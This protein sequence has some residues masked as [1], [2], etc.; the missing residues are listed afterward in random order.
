M[1]NIPSDVSM[2]LAI[3]W[4]KHNNSSLVQW[5]RLPNSFV[6]QYSLWQW[7]STSF[8]YFLRTLESH[9]VP[10]TSALHDTCFTNQRLFGVYARPSFPY[11]ITSQQSSQSF[12]LT[13]HLKPPLHSLRSTSPFHCLSFHNKLPLFIRG[14]FFLYLTKEWA[15][16]TI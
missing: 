5:T 8:S 9:T 16:H 1:L 10:C 12:S 3:E 7:L 2:V 13:L 6:S 11:P 14:T 4:A 15:K